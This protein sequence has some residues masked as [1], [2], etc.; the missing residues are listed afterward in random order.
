MLAERRR[1][2][3]M[4]K[5]EWKDGCKLGP[6]NTPLDAVKNT[7]FCDKHRLKMQELEKIEREK[8]Q[9]AKG[10]EA[11]KAKE[12]QMAKL[13]KEKQEAA[14]ERKQKIQQIRAQ[15]NQQVQAV[16]QQ[17]KQ[18]RAKHPDDHGINAGNNKAGNTAGGSDNPLELKLPN[19]A[20]GIAKGDIFPLLSGFDGSD[21]AGTKIRIN[22]SAG[23]ILIHV[24]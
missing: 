13:A 22:D 14:D 12:V 1:K 19:D 2:K 15:W 18:L 8:A 9:A 21:S 5:C 20:K 7:K 17:V 4:A 16:V 3:K 24:H 11:R 10:E 23:N 6:K